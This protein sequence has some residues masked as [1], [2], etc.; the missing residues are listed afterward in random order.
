MIHSMTGYG[1]V[2]EVLDGVSYSVEIRT[3]NNRYFKIN[4]RVPESVSFLE[5]TI[6]RFLR[7]EFSRGMVNFNLRLKNL[8]C[9]DLLEVNS[10][11]L[12]NYINQFKS[13]NVDCGTDVKIVDLMNLPG[14][15]VAPEPDEEQAEQITQ[16][17]LKVVT[18]AVEKVCQ[19]RAEEGKALVEDMLKNCDAIAEKLTIVE[20]RI[21]VVVEE[22]HEKLKKRIEH[23]LSTAKL[24][25]D[26][27]LL[28]REV[29]IF[30]DRCDI[31][32]ELARLKSH[33]SQFSDSC[34]SSGN[35]GKKL[36]FIAQEMLREA[37]TIA[38]KASDSLIAQCVVDVK[39]GIDRIK[40]QVQNVE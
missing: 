8:A 11:A 27:D 32:E 10:L 24:D 15:L 19:M 29:A 30:A 6:E 26:Q 21:D 3:V 1:Q 40:E 7:N 16:N 13:L 22:Y 18:L 5:D 31:A 33:F 37:N 17:C 35:A 14:V 20:G 2:T 36:D 28:A 23:L 39:C 9:A 38:S 34:N 12:E 25:I 4:T